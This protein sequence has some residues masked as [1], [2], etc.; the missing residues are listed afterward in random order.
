MLEKLYWSSMCVIIKNYVKYA[1]KE[2]RW[3]DLWVWHHREKFNLK[4]FE[5]LMN[6]ILIKK[7]VMTVSRIFSHMMMWNS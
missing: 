7:K 3:A 4:I 6:V 5:I 1:E 2:S